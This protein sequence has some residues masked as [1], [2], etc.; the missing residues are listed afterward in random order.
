M[1]DLN[2]IYNYFINPLL[3]VYTKNINIILNIN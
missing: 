1:F 3:Q 2:Q